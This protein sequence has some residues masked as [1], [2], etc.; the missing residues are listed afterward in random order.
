MKGIIMQKQFTL[1]AFT[2]ALALSV[3]GVFSVVAQP[4]TQ[5]S[6][7][8]ENQNPPQRILINL[9]H[10]TDDLHAAIMALKIANGL[11]DRGAEVTML[12]NLEGV[13]L[14]DKNAPGDLK[15]GTSDASPAALLNS[16]LNAGGKVMVCPHCSAAVGIGPDDLREGVTMS[17]GQ[18]SN[19]R[20]FLEADKVIG[21]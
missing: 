7:T 11:Q 15:W 5:S 16:F 19:I 20:A 10:Y 14:V 1:L 3:I 17:S 6:S 12:L 18:D 13:R 21:Y 2:A 9:K 4:A 8:I